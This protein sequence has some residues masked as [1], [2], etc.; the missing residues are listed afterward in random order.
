MRQQRWAL[1][2]EVSVSGGAAGQVEVPG[3]QGSGSQRAARMS[4]CWS[5]ISGKRG[6][7]GAGSCWWNTKMASL[8]DPSVVGLIEYWGQDV[9]LEARVRVILG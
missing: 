2:D 3:G 1:R 9:S 6:A 4:N 5:G 8:E 7:V